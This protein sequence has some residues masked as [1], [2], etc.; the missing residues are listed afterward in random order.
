MY[1]LTIV[2]FSIISFINQ[3]VCSPVAMKQK[4]QDFDISQFF[5]LLVVQK[6]NTMYEMNGF[7]GTM[8]LTD[9]Q[10]L[11]QFS[12]IEFYDCMLLHYLKTEALWV[13]SDARNFPP[14]N[15]V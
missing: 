8:F 13:C 1:T 10:V 2:S 14:R 3:D 9:Y 5:C 6:A 4:S 7:W 11:K 12:E 15:T